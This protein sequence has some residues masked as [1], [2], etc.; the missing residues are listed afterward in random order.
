[1]RTSNINELKLIDMELAC[2]LI[3]GDET[4]AKELLIMLKDSLGEHLHCIQQEYTNKDYPELSK[5]VH[6][7]HGATCY[8]GTPRLKAAC[9]Q[10]ESA[11]KQ[12]LDSTASDFNF[13][14]E[15]IKK[16]HDAL[17]NL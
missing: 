5:A 16:T 17:N 14:I 2:E 4:M 1:M 12:K 6:K 7:L 8:T 9:Q 10:L 13:L 3:S 11:A 15:T